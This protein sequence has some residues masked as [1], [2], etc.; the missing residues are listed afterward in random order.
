MSS[1][2]HYTLNRGEEVTRAGPRELL[3]RETRPAHEA[4][5]ARL[6][7]A[8]ERPDEAVYEDHLKFLLGFHAPVERA[9]QHVAGLATRVPQLLLRY[10]T[11]SLCADL[12]G[13]D[14]GVRAPIEDVPRPRSPAAAF[15]VLYV[16]EGSTL[17]ARSLLPRLRRCG[18]IPAGVGTRYFEA[19]GTRTGEMW[20]TF[21]IALDGLDSLQANRALR[22]AEATFEALS[23][24]RDRWETGHG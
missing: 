19:Y 22:A 3:R 14:S 21:C 8:G 17:G 13:R 11:A 9:L 18:A 24:W 20:R 10:K 2:S 4:L 5:E 15:G 6:P 12:G 23:A 7:I 1:A 16:L